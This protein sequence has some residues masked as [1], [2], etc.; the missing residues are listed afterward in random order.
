M[1]DEFNLHP[2]EKVSVVV[3]TRMKRVS[4]GQL[5]DSAEVYDIGEYIYRPMVD[6][7]W[8]GI[9]ARDVLEEAIKWWEKQLRKGEAI[10][11]ERFLMIAELL[12]FELKRK[13][14]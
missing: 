3:Q 11:I 2:L 8:E 6:G 12:G 10:E 4:D 7:P 13:N 9:D 5:V 1:W 14:L